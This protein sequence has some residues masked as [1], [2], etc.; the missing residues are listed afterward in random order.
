MRRRF[1]RAASDSDRSSALTLEGWYV[2]G[3]FFCFADPMQRA[4]KP[5]PYGRGS[6]FGD[7][8]VGRTAGLAR[9]AARPRT[10]GR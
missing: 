6:V 2:F 1:D 8:D 3:V 4:L 5:L 9:E 10:R 7:S